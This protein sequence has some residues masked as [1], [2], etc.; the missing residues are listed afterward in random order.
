MSLDG[1]FSGQQAQDTLD[2]GRKGK[3]HST[4][5]LPFKTAESTWDSFN[6]Q[7]TD[8]FKRV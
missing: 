6:I 2:T 7:T 5:A 8:Q 1:I 3:A 4:C